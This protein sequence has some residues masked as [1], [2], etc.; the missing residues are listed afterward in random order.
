M[1]RKKVNKRRYIIVGIIT[2]FIFLLGIFLGSFIDSLKYGYVEEVVEKQRLDLSSLQIQ[3]LLINPLEKNQ[4]CKALEEVI[5]TNLRTLQPIL[6][7]LIE[8]E[9]GEENLDQSYI[10]LKREYLQANIRYFLLA[11][12]SRKLCNSS[13]VSVLYF[14][15]D[16]C[17]L[18]N[19]EGYILTNLR[20]HFNNSLLVFPIDSDFKEEPLVDILLKTYNVTSYPTFVIEDEVVRKYLPRE[21]LKQKICSKF[22]QQKE[23]CK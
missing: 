13:Y 12:R 5:K 9:E 3:S 16:E 23:Q 20:I 6:E 8:Y 17:K 15:N 4:S 7:R 22:L 14:F 11:E 2:S 18:C 21:E 19:L 1:R 10:S